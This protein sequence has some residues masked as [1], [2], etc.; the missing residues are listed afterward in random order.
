MWRASAGFVRL[1]AWCSA[2]GWAN[3]EITAPDGDRWIERGMNLTDI[4]HAQMACEERVVELLN[5][6]IGV[7]DP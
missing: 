5:E 7:I 1:I 3:W 2:P 6:A 4:T